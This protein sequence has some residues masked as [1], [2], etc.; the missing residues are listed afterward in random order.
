LMISRKKKIQMLL[1]LLFLLQWARL[2]AIQRK[3]LQEQ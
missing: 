3:K 2:K 1:L